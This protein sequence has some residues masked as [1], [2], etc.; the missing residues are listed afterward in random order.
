MDL[1]FSAEQEAFRKEVREWMAVHVPASGEPDDRA[2]L[3]E[4]QRGVAG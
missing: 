1:T 4:Y 3:V 2:E